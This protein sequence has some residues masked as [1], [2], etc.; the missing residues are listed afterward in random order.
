MQRE[1]S[2]ESNENKNFQIVIR[3][4]KDEEFD[5]FQNTLNKELIIELY[6][7]FK[8]FEKKGIINYDIYMESMTEIFKKYNKE[9]DFKSIF[10]LIFNR[11][12]K[13]K[14]ILKNN[15]TVFYMTEMVRK[16]EIETYIIA[17]FLTILIKCKIFDKIKLLFNLTDVDDDGLLNKNEIKLMISTINFLFCENSEI[18][19]NSSILSQSLMNIKVKTKINKLMNDP[20]NLNLILHQEKYVDFD[21][22][23]DCLQKIENY[24]YEII[25]CFINIRKCLYNKRAEKILEIKNKIKKEFV[26]ESSALSNMKPKT[27]LQLMK[28]NFSASLNRVIKNV[29]LKNES[30]IDL[31]VRNFNS[32]LKRKKNLLLG[33]KERN[34]S[35]KELLKE[36]SI[37]AENEGENNLDKSEI[38][39][40][41]S[42]SNT[43]KLFKINTFRK[44]S[45]N[46]PKYI[47]EA[48]FDKIKKIEVEPALLK[49][50]GEKTFSKNIRRYNSN[51][52]IL[53]SKLDE[54][55]N[56]KNFGHKTSM[57]FFNTNKNNNIKIKN[58]FQEFPQNNKN[59]IRLKNN[60]MNLMKRSS[61]YPLNYKNDIIQNLNVNLFQNITSAK[62]HNN[63]LKD[64]HKAKSSLNKILE[65]TDYN[66]KTAKNNINRLNIN[67]KTDINKLNKQSIIKLK[68]N[69][70][71]NTPINHFI[72]E[73][74]LKI[75][76]RN[77]NKTNINKI[78]SM[79]IIENKTFN[80]KETDKISNKN[81]NKSYIKSNISKIFHD[82][83]KNA[84]N[85]NS[86][87]NKK[88][89]YSLNNKLNKYMNHNEIMKDLDDEDKKAHELSYYLE[90]DLITL[91][92]KIIKEKKKLKGSLNNMDSSD[93][94]MDFYNIGKIDLTSKNKKHKIKKLE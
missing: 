76:L 77:Y 65:K 85:A 87:Y 55:F 37:L 46:K 90:K 16:N 42:S 4:I 11:F 25:P 92:N 67:K 62:R 53:N 54:N 82:R 6:S 20:G 2:K 15:K 93:M 94:S 17:C 12:Q 9:N 24:K 5:S 68:N 44:K 64:F 31:D 33:L 39:K 72:K 32:E 52:N 48:D 45:S 18:N 38:N 63:S 30:D 36:S 28:K 73:R 59:N 79:K 51:I 43:D 86:I 58:I 81:N 29:K 70:R 88:K 66:S 69:Y 27:P 21:T 41:S 78:N 3:D 26:Q 84:K 91:Y 83:N 35:F 19:I 49:F 50:S 61:I 7:I 80:K 47:F 10:D 22:F 56:P 13:I 23:F 71:F 14:C 34:K 74:K 57:E 89:F 8:I 75:K 1:E 40:N 60:N